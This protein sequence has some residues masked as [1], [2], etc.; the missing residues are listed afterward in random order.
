VNQDDILGILI[1]AMQVDS[2]KAVLAAL[3][4]NLGIAIFKLTA[5][6]ISGSSTMMAEAYHSISDTFNQVLLLYGLRKSKK[7][8]D[9]CHRFGYGKEQYFWS[10]MVA[11]F[12]FGIAGTLSVREGYHKLQHPEP[13]QSIW[14]A[15]L[16]ILVGLIFEGF[17]LRVAY[18]NIRREIDEEKH[19]T[20]LEAVRD[21]KDPTTLTVLFEDSLAM[22]GL[23]IA[24]VAITI[25]QFSGLLIIDAIASITIGVLLMVFAVF[26]AYETKKLL[27]GEA[28]TPRKRNMILESINTFVEV[29]HV[30]SMKSMHLSPKDVLV[31]LEINY[32]D[33]LTISQLE[34]VND[35][36]E[37]T[38]KEILPE[39]KIYLEAEN[40]EE[41]SCRIK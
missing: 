7:P 26:L 30:I 3:F 8:A 6:F 41:T 14:L 29:N 21:S 24:A 25:V 1:N 11:I 22:V 31:A 15:Y 28:V 9:E 23:I 32:A 27:V 38:I 16:A 2:K 34:E 4:G 10:F 17:A 18:L 20:F 19:E 40:M 35:R 37:G 33:G 39:A 5:A 13:L 36:I 12:L